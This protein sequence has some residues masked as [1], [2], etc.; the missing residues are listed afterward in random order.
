MGQMLPTPVV[1]P[2]PLN[3]Y[4]IFSNKAL[5]MHVLID[6][7]LC[8]EVLPCTLDPFT[9]RLHNLCCY[10]PYFGSKLTTK[11]YVCNSNTHVITYLQKLILNLSQFA[12]LSLN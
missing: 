11:Q 8:M 2:C 9:L 7:L 3:P 4:V 10:I 5:K 6:L 12:V 1:T